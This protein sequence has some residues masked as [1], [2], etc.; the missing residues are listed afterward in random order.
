[1]S[2]TYRK[3]YVH[4]IWGTFGRRKVLRGAR[5]HFIHHHIWTISRLDHIN[6]IAMNS[7]LDHIHILAEWHPEVDISS[8]VRR[9]KSS[10]STM[11]NRQPDVRTHQRMRWQRGYGLV[12]LRHSGVPTVREYIR[13][14]KRH[15]GLDDLDDEL[16]RIFED[17]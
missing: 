2:R 13:N 12:T 16:E 9:W 4:L 14:Q 8:V 5:E 15:H 7:A 1:M 17:P 6:I 10:S 11:W 3:Y